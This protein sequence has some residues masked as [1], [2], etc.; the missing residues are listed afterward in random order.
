[1]KVEQRK[2][3]DYRTTK[4][5]VGEGTTKDSAVESLVY[6]LHEE[7]QSILFGNGEDSLKFEEIEPQFKPVVITLETQEEVDAL[8]TLVNQQ[9]I[10]E[11]FPALD[12]WW[13]KL[14]GLGSYAKY[15][16]K[17]CRIIKVRKI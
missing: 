16:S 17:L 8:V 3:K 4:T 12:D 13:K 6:A 2:A 10:T 15:W 14:D 7:R 5:V 9:R 1:M 11:V